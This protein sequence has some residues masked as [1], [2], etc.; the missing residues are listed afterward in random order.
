MLKILALI[1]TK[2]N[3]FKL[4]NIDNAILQLSSIKTKNLVKTASA[5]IFALISSCKDE[6]LK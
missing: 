5:S 4:I 6:K 3:E 1:F 2:L